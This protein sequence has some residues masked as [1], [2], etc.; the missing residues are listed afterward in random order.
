MEAIGWMGHVIIFAYMSLLN[1]SNLLEARGLKL[2]LV[3][4]NSSCRN[5]GA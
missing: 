5:V 3:G 1:S 2:C 4:R